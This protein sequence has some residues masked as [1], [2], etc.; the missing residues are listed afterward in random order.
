MK[1]SRGRAKFKM[2]PTD[3]ARAGLQFGLNMRQLGM[4][5]EESQIVDDEEEKMCDK[6]IAIKSYK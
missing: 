1:E 3:G 5:M 4:V 2:L 6:G